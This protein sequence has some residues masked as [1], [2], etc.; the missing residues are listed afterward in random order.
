MSE[1]TVHAIVNPIAGGGRTGRLIPKLL[2]E[3]ER[4]FGTDC[5]I[6]TTRQPLEATNITRKSII[7]GAK[8]II[9]MG[10]DGTVHEAVNGFFNDRKLLNPECELG[11]LNFGTGKGLLQTLNLPSSLEEQLDLIACSSSNLLDVGC[12]VYKDE[13]GKKK[14]CLFLNECQVGIGGDVVTEV[15]IKHKYFGGTLAFGSVAIK[16]ALFYKALNLTV[17]FDDKQ[18]ISRNLIG[19]VAGNGA[20]CA[21][22][23]RLTPDARPDDGQFDVLLIHDMNIF[24]RIWNFTKI[25]SGKH[26]KSQYVTLRRSK[27]LSIGSEKPALIEADGE[28]LGTVPCEIS[29]LPAILKVKSNI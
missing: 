10:G 16:Q 3:I 23:M 1:K 13:K 26:I 19:V 29:L 14:E 15:S 6:H 22:G 2:A 12:V 21:G 11:I 25:Y 17:E 5:I 7:T 27:S 9:V 20:F 18:I 24:N 4:R 28:L 8:L